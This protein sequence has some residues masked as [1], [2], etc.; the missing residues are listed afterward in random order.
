MS[1]RAA[2]KPARKQPTAPRAR[3]VQQSTRAAYTAAENAAEI[4]MALSPGALKA[5]EESKERG[6]S[7]HMALVRAVAESAV[8][9]AL[10]ERSLPH[11]WDEGADWY[12]TCDAIAE[13]IMDCPDD[14]WDD[15][16]PEGLNPDEVKG[17][18]RS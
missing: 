9:L 8:A 14:D 7:K 15:F 2:R 4:T 6:D 13:K 12:L 17:R 3:A 16:W 10:V 1:K 11:L 18:I 5:F